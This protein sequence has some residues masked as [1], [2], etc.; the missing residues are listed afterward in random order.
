MQIRTLFLVCFFLLSYHS[1]AQTENTLK[2]SKHRYSLDSYIAVGRINTIS[3]INRY[4]FH[5]IPGLNFGMN[6]SKRSTLSVGAN[7]SRIHDIHLIIHCDPDPCPNMLDYKFV[8]VSVGY[9]Y[10]VYSNTQFSIEPFISLYQEITIYKFGHFVP[11]R[12]M[13]GIPYETPFF[14]WFGGSAGAYINYKISDL[15]VVFA[16]PSISYIGSFVY[17]DFIGSSFGTRITF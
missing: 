13:E 3:Y 6:I 12:Y 5:A 14:G 10:R 1:F 11:G 17:K 9:K 16:R 4:R 2:E 7:Y 8:N 15:A